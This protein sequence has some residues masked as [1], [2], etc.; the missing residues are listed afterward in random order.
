MKKSTG[1]KFIM[2]DFSKAP[3]LVL[4]ELTRACKLACKHCRAEAINER[5]PNELTIEQCSEMLDELAKFERPPLIVLTGG[6]PANR[7]DLFEII[8]E[9]KRRNFTVA[10]T[11]SGTETV[12]RS[13][14]KK[15]KEAGLERIAI[16]LDA[17]N[18]ENHDYFRGVDGS[19]DW[20]VNILNWAKEFDLPIQINTTIC[21]NNYDLFD[22]MAS[23]VEQ[24]KA[25]LWSVFFLVPVGRADN[26]MQ[27]TATEAEKIMLKMATLSQNSSFDIKSTACPQFRRVLIQNQNRKYSKIKK[28]VESLSK[29]DSGYNLGR[30]RSI[31]AVNDACGLMFVSHTG[32]V[33]PSGFLPMNAGNV[34]TESP[35]DIY[36]NSL[37]FKDLRDRSLLKGKCGACSFKDVCGG[38]RARA[39]GYYGDIQAED[40]LCLYHEASH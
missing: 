12:T 6:D 4:W 28:D 36:Q 40:P 17:P 32:E 7:E 2:P 1:K 27:I 14:V 9:C 11:P 3:F 10:M 26:E 15:L 8:Q 22:E 21:R 20:S 34:K 16:S 30:L 19:F 25:V 37:L 29:L 23:T 33:F 24:L 35:V 38:S 13:L 31:G 5:N 18:K 39:F